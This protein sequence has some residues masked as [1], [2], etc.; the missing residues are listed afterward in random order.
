M[1]SDTNEPNALTKQEISSA[2]TLG[3]YQAFTDDI[4]AQQVLDA[5]QRAVYDAV[6]DLVRT[7]GPYPITSDDIHATILKGVTEA[8]SDRAPE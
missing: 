6:I 8:M 3:V 1:M 5:I 7:T 2:I 4:T